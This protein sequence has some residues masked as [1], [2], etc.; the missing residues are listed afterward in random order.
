MSIIT[1]RDYWMSVFILLWIFLFF[2]GGKIGRLA[3]F[4]IIP[5]LILADQSSSHWLKPIIARIRPCHTLPDA[6]LLVGCGGEFSFPS[7][8]ATNS[9]AAA[10]LFSYFYRNYR[11]FLFGM[12][13]LVSFSRIYV[14]VH[15]PADVLAGIIL[16]IV[17]GALIIFI[18][19]ASTYFYFKKSRSS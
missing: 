13:A 19:K 1:N 17:C 16:G 18:Y 7:G 2:K 11:Y 14:G 8:H 4:L 9:F 3:A 15:Y 12:A 10:L 6:R 5:T